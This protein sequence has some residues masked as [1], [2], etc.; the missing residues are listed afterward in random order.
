[1]Q[2]ILELLKYTVPSL[3]VFLTAFFL[4]KVYLDSE[5]KKILLEIKKSNQNSI[6]PLRL[7]AYERMVLLMERLSPNS[8]IM[9]VKRSGMTAADLQVAL[10]AEVRTEFDHNL[11]QQ[12]Y[13][14]NEAWKL[15]KNTK[16]EIIKLINL[17]YSKIRAEDSA[18]ELSKAIFDRFMALEQSPTQK[19]IEYLKEEARELF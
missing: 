11:S 9:R 19:V 15:V 14:S 1:M 8:L 3:V 16:E 10:H 5:Q 4:I 18:L 2:E 17:S 13:I 7:Q 6:L 12:L